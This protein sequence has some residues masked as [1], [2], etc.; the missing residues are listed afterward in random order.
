M[1][2]NWMEK[3]YAK[4]SEWNDN[5]LNRLP[6]II[7]GEYKRLFE[8][9]QN[10]NVFGLFLQIKDTYEV[11]V[12][13][14]TLIAATIET[15]NGVS[16]KNGDWLF[17]FFEKDLALGD[18]N[19][20]CHAYSKIVSNGYLKKILEKTKKLIDSS[21]IIK[22]RN[23]W[24]GHGALAQ[25]TNEKFVDSIK[26]KIEFIFRFVEENLMLLE[27]MNLILDKNE[28]KIVNETETISLYPWIITKNKRTYLFDSYRNNKKKFV[29]LDYE[30]GGKNECCIDKLK[31]LVESLCM[32]NTVRKFVNRVDDD[33]ILTSEDMVIKELKKT[34]R[35]IR[36]EYLCQQIIEFTNLPKGIML[37]QMGEEFGKTSLATALDNNGLNRIKIPDCM[38]RAYYINYIV[39]ICQCCQ[40]MI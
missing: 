16:E 23:D 20:I 24:V 7:S 22:W 26:E 18:W 17:K 29:Y 36:P 8:L 6:K 32:Q 5:N 37:L 38:T 31:R 9:L 11:F 15:K 33:L 14:P 27:Q 30:N 21:N 3:E 4:Y 40:E 39:E 28:W 10:K 35:Y 13:I 19:T 34:Q 12:K 2:T 1:D 25:E